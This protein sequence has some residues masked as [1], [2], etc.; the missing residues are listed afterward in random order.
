MA[1]S[2]ALIKAGVFNPPAMNVGAGAYNKQNP[3]A[4]SVLGTSGVLGNTAQGLLQMEL[5]KGLLK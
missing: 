2:D 5:L 3:W 1:T 4:Q